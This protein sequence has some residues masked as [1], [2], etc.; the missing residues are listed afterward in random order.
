M[1]LHATPTSATASMVNNR[2]AREMRSPAGGERLWR[3][4]GLRRVDPGFHRVTTMRAF[5]T[6]VS[7]AAFAATLG[8]WAAPVAAATVLNVNWSEGCG[9][10]TCFDDNG[11]Y[12]KT[13]SASQFNG[14]V[15]IGQLLMQRGVLGAL[16]GSTFRIS[17]R[18]N[19][20]ELGTWGHW[21]MA[22]IG[23]DE[24]NFAGE[25]FTWN[26]EDG[27]LELI[28]SI[29]PPPR[30]G[31]GG[32]YFASTLME[33]GETGPTGGGLNPEAPGPDGPAAPLG[34][35]DLAG[36]IPEPATW[37]M[38]IAGFGMAGALLRRRRALLTA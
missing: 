12:S 25:N 21:N 29:A 13:F 28:L 33:G 4:S 35:T 7:A 31:A 23:G 38:M 15:T 24:L 36:A 11:T 19:G 10:A 20:E 30:Q 16:D 26:P 17:F 37:A 22:G 32:G 2:L 6:T 8:L 1:Q 5:R 18:L 34:P 9:K 3:H 27:D 14:P